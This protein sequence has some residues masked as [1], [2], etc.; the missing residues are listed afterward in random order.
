MSPLTLV[1]AMSLLANPCDASR[2]ERVQTVQSAAREW[3]S[4]MKRVFPVQKRIRAVCR[5]VLNTA[6]QT[7]IRPGGGGTLVL[8]SEPVGGYTRVC[9]PLPKGV[10]GE[11]VNRLLD[12]VTPVY[13][14]APVAGHVAC[15]QEDLAHGIDTWT[16]RNDLDG[17]GKVVGWKP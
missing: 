5:D 16:R 2:E 4:F 12:E 8:R 14:S 11:D 6:R 13:L 10:T 3:I 9:G 1:L 7:V 17:L 15:W